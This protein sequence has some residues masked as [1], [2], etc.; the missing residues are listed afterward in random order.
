MKL[1]KGS[2]QEAKEQKFIV[3]TVNSWI[4]L[5]FFLPSPAWSAGNVLS[6]DSMISLLSCHA[7]SLLSRPCLLQL[8]WIR[9]HGGTKY[10]ITASEPHHESPKTEL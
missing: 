10:E 6:K 3:L 2:I 4:I 1:V 5:G 8:S 9:V 7:T